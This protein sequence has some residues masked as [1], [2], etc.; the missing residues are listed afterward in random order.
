M[1]HLTQQVDHAFR[2]HRPVAVHEPLEVETLQEFHHVIEAPIV[3]HTEVEELHRV[4][5]REAGCHL[6][7]TLESSDDVV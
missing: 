5:R 3:G 6:R 1:T 7:F 4:R 2:R